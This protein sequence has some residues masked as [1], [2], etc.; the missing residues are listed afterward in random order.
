VERLELTPPTGGGALDLS[1]RLPYPSTGQYS[2]TRCTVTPRYGIIAQ[3]RTVWLHAMADI[4]LSYAKEDREV[5][6]KLSVLLEHAG[7]SVW[8]DRRIPAGRTWRDVLEEALREMGC[9]VVLWTSH[10]VDS[11]WVREEAEEARTRRKLVPVLIESVNP[12]VGFRTIQAAD[13]TDWDGVVESPGARQ[14]IADLALL[15]GKP[16]AKTP[17]AP[18]PLV[19]SSSSDVAIDTG[20]RDAAQAKRSP[21]PQDRPGVRA[22][23]HSEIPWKLVAAIGG[24]AALALALF[25]LWPERTPVTD[26]LSTAVAPPPV[27]PAVPPAPSLVNLSIYGERQ[28]LDPDEALKLS[29][30][31]R[32][33]DGSESDISDAVEWASSDAKVAKV[34]GAGRLTA[35]QSGTTKITA[36]Y[37]G[38]SS[39]VWSLNV[40]TLPAKPAPAPSLVALAVDSDKKDI[41]PREKILLR[42]AGKF[43]DGSNKSV[44]GVDWS[45][46]NSAIASVNGRGELEAWRAGK[47]A[48]VARSGNISS[49]PFWVIVKE[50]PPKPVVIPERIYTPER[51]YPEEAPRK[52]PDYT[53]VERSPQPRPVPP[54][55]NTE[56]LRAKIAPHISQA[57]DYRVRGNY[58]GALTA[59][60]AA[61]SA[62]MPG[63]VELVAEVD[64][65]IEQTK[66]ACLA[67]KRLGRTDLDCG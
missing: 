52:A 22:A 18:T 43:S 11:D 20:S 38:L 10:S 44:A 48:V 30:R 8:W 31:A 9:M 28:E 40:K 53:S 45:S 65:E 50:L 33:S 54:P 47:T 46:S 25:V 59:L 4:F 29:L 23:V 49:A 41:L 21:Q 1:A 57:R 67:E 55:V 60:S 27:E 19:S 63:G 42:A 7:W 62:A 36:T 56:A 39:P 15:I 58:V 14:L 16:A 5:A 3:P 51:S 6:R 24:S 13:L 61:R 17:V 2:C 32:Y 12:P 64:R 34:D 37:A 26:E 35:L 66:R